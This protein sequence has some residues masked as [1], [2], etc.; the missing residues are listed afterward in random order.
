[1]NVLPRSWQEPWPALRRLNALSPLDSQA[2]AAIEAALAEAITVPM[3]GD[4]LVEGKPV[5]EP[6]II[7]EGW[8]ARVR[9]QMD[10]SRQFLSFLLP[11]DLIG[12]CDQPDPLTTTTV[13]ALTPVRTT[14]APSS[15][16][17]PAL[18]IVYALSK[19]L[20]EAYL[21][22][23]IARLGRLNAQER[24]LHLLLE[25]H[26]RL[27]LAGLASGGSF[28]MP[29]T[30]EQLADALGLTSVHVN[31]MLQR[32]RRES[33]LVWSGKRVVIDEPDILARRIGRNPAKVSAFRP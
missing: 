14:V 32:A 29:L 24:I 10:G 11:G 7:V 19:A 8:A 15:D 31:R 28:D 30:Q 16:D 26:E 13:T 9:I 25:L 21:L 5:G 33:G 17:L 27:G 2:C 4:L 12:L 22:D 6:R 20:E 3:R 1:M 18:A 23:H